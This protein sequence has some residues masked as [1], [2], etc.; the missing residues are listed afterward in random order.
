MNIYVYEIYDFYLSYVKF[1]T[2]IENSNLLQ[3]MGICDLLTK[4]G[5]YLIL[6]ITRALSWASTWS[7]NLLLTKLIER[8]LL[9]KFYEWLYK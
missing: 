1:K 7:K 6:F 3:N 9:D 2:E 4:K 8:S 5:T